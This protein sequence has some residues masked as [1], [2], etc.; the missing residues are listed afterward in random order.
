MRKIGCVLLALLPLTAWA[1]PIEV[2][3]HLNG[4]GIDYKAFDTD[5]DIGSILVNNH[6]KTDAR[7]TVVFRNGP[8]SPRTRKI[9]VPAG[10]SK[11]ATAKFTRGII[12]LRLDLTCV[13]K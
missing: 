2:E 9:E 12:T 7:C 6:G 13:P 5:A 8:E 10:Q 1:Y 4:L 11:N 3:K